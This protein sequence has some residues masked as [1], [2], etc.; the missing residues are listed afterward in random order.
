MLAA[1]TVPV[2][3]HV[4]EVR[5]AAAKGKILAL[6][7]AEVI[8]GG[9]SFTLDGV[10]V[11]RTKDLA[12]GKDGIGVDVPRYRASDGAWRPAVHL[13]EELRKPLAHAILDECCVLG[14]TQRRE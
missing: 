4:L 13:P 9:V 7:S 8:I 5:P 14:I 12:T 11:I 10:Q 1:E 2:T 6:A 3:V